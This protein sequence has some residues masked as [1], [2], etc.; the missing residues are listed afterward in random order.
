MEFVTLESVKVSL[1]F[2]L[3]PTEL[4]WYRQIKN[5]SGAVLLSHVLADRFKGADF[6]QILELARN[7]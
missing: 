1:E 5:D 4:K 2:T 7:I 3:H 6:K